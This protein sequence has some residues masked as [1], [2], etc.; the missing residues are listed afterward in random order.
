MYF[1]Y[2]PGILQTKKANLKMRLALKMIPI[3]GKP[4]I[5]DNI[6]FLILYK[7]IGFHPMGKLLQFRI[8]SIIKKR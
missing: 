3:G 6:A 2:Y 5:K 7:V 1:S 8:I 4:L